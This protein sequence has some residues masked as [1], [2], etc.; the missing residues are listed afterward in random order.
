VGSRHV[1]YDV[2]AGTAA[3]CSKT[4]NKELLPYGLTANQGSAQLVLGCSY[5]GIS[6]TNNK[7]YDS[8]STLPVINLTHAFPTKINHLL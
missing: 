6:V 4:P 8:A 5:T 7:L 1:V 2:D 3:C